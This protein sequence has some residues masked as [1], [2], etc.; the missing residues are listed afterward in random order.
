MQKRQS[1][2]RERQNDFGPADTGNTEESATRAHIATTESELQDDRHSKEESP[3]VRRRRISEV[4]REPS[5]QRLA[6]DGSSRKDKELAKRHL[7]GHNYSQ[8]IGMF[9]QHQKCLDL[10]RSS[11][12][13]SISHTQTNLAS[14]RMESPPRQATAEGSDFGDHQTS[15]LIRDDNDYYERSDIDRQVSA[16]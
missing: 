14:K 8:M 16:S 11:N 5:Q 9:D 1:P 10:G 3:V 6:T 12:F 15:Q 4:P 2:D 7:P 13:D